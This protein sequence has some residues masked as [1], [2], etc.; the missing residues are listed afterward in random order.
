MSM[1]HALPI[2]LMTRRKP[3]KYNVPEAD[4]KRLAKAMVSIFMRNRVVGTRAILTWRLSEVFQNVKGDVLP[5]VDL[6]EWMK[7]QDGG[8]GSV[9]SDTCR[10][11][12]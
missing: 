10:K 9:Y 1:L 4:F 5:I 6:I 12:F 7:G 3:Y 8:F 11:L 2:L